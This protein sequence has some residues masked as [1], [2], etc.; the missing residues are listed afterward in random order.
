MAIEKVYMFQNTSILSDEM[1][2][3][4]LGLVPINANPELF[5]YV[6]LMFFPI[7]VL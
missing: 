1:V 5:Q 2:S 4:R 7:F 6:V 3:H